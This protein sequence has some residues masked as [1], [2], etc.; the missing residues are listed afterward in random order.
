MGNTGRG[1]SATG[2]RNKTSLNA[3]IVQAVIH[4][5]LTAYVGR[6]YPAARSNST[7]MEQDALAAW[8]RI[9]CRAS[10]KL[11][12]FRQC[13]TY[14]PA[15][16]PSAEDTS[17]KPD[18]SRMASSN[19]SWKHPELVRNGLRPALHRICAI[20][21]AC[22]GADPDGEIGRGPTHRR[23]PNSARRGRSAGQRGNF[24]HRDI[25][26]TTIRQMERQ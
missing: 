8:T 22:A 18:Q 10:D 21:N 12:F 7:T 17:T 20:F 25:G 3:S 5:P 23:A 26:T 4:L 6:V 9:G 15:R 24:G 13:A 14:G 2:P 16:L 11:V 19:C 1:H